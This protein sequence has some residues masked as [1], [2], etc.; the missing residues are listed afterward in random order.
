MKLRASSAPTVMICPQSMR[1]EDDIDSDN[2]A[3]RMGVACHEGMALHIKGQRM[4]DIHDLCLRHRIEGSE[5]ELGMLLGYGRAAWAELQDKFPAI[6]VEQA[7]EAKLSDEL[8]LTGHPDGYSLQ[9]NHVR[10]LDWKSGRVRTNYYHQM[11]SYGV[12]CCHALGVTSAKVTTVWLRDG[13]YETHNV[14]AHQLDATVDNLHEAI[15]SER[16]VTGAHCCNCSRFGECKALNQMV[17]GALAMSGEVAEGYNVRDNAMKLHLPLHGLKAG[18]KAYE[19]L[20]TLIRAEIVR[21]GEPIL[22]MDGELYL[23]D[24][25]RRKLVDPRIW[26]PIVA[27]Y[28]TQEQLADCMGRGLSAVKTAVGSNAERGQKG[29]RISEVMEKLDSA[30]CIEENHFTELA[31]S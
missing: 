26:G 18:A 16:Y 11:C 12:L 15:K 3:A 22:I 30:G 13:E 21:S 14:Q 2:D 24:K 25:C 9:S 10:I 28:V 4:P 31:I 19:Q 29:K 6:V 1:G 8:T 20:R 17:H 7:L 27:N 23:K 5:D